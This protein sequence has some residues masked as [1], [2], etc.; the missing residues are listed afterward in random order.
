MPARKSHGS[1]TISHLMGPMLVAIL[2]VLFLGFAAVCAGVGAVFT[3]LA[4]GLARRRSAWLLPI[5]VVVS[6]LLGAVAAIL[7]GLLQ[8]WN[9]VGDAIFAQPLLGYAAWG[10]IGFGLSTAAA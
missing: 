7:F 10:S 4:V 9:I 5:Y 6:G 8:R 2:V 1:H 3:T